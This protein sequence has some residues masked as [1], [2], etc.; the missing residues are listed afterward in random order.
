MVGV[1]L[2]AAQDREPFAV[3]QPLR[4]QLVVDG[5][6]EA[7]GPVFDHDDVREAQAERCGHDDQED[8]AEAR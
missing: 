6:V 4:L 1:R 8:R 7:V 2:V 3:R 5:V